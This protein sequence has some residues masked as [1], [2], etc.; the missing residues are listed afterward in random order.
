MKE[1][2]PITYDA[3]KQIITIAS[4][5]DGIVR[6]SSEGGFPPEG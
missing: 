1:K 6:L 3:E 5:D 2:L 4:D